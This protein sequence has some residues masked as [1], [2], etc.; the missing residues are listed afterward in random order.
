MI[1]IISQQTAKKEETI[2]QKTTEAAKLRMDI[3]KL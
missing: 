2:K 3:K 1:F